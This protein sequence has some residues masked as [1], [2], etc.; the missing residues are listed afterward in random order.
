[1]SLSNGAFISNFIDLAVLR[2]NQNYFP[3]GKCDGSSVWDQVSGGTVAR[4]LDQPGVGQG[5]LLTGDTASPAGWPQ[6][7][8]DPNY[9]WGNTRNGTASEADNGVPKASFIQVGRDYIQSAKPGYTPYAYPHP[10]TGGSLAPA[11]TSGPP[12]PSNVRIVS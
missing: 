5:L 3:W 9:I 4:C 8:T 7:A 6:Q 1:L 11:P 12:P 10:L 2:A